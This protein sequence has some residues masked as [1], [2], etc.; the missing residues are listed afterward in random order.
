M[1]ETTWNDSEAETWG[2]KRLQIVSFQARSTN[3]SAEKDKS[4]AFMTD[5]EKCI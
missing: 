2:A 3:L 5:D 4:Y 1:F